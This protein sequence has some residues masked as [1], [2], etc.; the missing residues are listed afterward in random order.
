MQVSRCSRTCRSTRCYSRW[1][2]NRRLAQRRDNENF[3][4]NSFRAHEMT[5]FPRRDG[6]Y[7]HGAVVMAPASLAFSQALHGCAMN[8]LVTPVVLVL[9][10]V[11]LPENAGGKCSQQHPIRRRSERGGHLAS[12]RPTM[13]TLLVCRCRVSVWRGE[14]KNAGGS[15]S[16]YKLECA[17]SSVRFYERTRKTWHR[18][19]TLQF[20]TLTFLIAHLNF[21]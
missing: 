6:G 2:H 7:L 11:W 15:C 8:C 14:L 10:F 3:L 5:T 4:L 19:K 13:A 16:G 1:E 18:K 12:R 17:I 9:G 20:I 21:T